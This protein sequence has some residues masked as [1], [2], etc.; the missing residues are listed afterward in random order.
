MLQERAREPP[1]ALCPRCVCV[2]LV[3]ASQ[4]ECHPD[5]DSLGVCS[6]VI[7]QVLSHRSQ[8]V[9]SLLI[10]RLPFRLS[11]R[12]SKSLFRVDNWL[13]LFTLTNCLIYFSRCS[14]TLCSIGF[15]LCKAPVRARCL[16]PRAR[17]C[18]PGCSLRLSPWGLPVSCVL[19]PPLSPLSRVPGLAPGSPLGKP[20]W[21]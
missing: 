2:V 3:P 12:V 14:D 21:W 10:L 18:P 8:M 15:S 20:A 16:S 13:L 11:V 4:C 7:T 9:N 5:V 19:G 1:S 6:S 17:C